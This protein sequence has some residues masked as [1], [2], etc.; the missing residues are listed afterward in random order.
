VLL[1]RYPKRPLARL[2][3]CAI[4]LLAVVFTGSNAALLSL[5]LGL[6]GVGFF[7]LWRRADAVVA[8]AVSALIGVLVV[9]AT[10]YAVSSDLIQRIST[11]SNTLVERSL[12]R[13]SKSATGRGTLFG[14]EFELYR[15]GSLLGRGPANTKANL[16]PS[17]AQIVKEAHDDYLATLVERGPL[18]VVGLIILMGAVGV[19]AAAVAMRP[20][21]PRFA[22]IVTF[23]A[24]FI[25]CVITM[26]ATA[27]THEVLHYRH[28]WAILGILAGLYLFGHETRAPVPTLLSGRP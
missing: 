4:I 28:V 11:S 2:Y 17:F 9:G 16:D 21:V 10:Y 23:P 26:A 12:A 27:T 22:E 24:M 20:L 6:A 3:A 8:V 5:A 13:S 1:G 25:G 7:T 19:R 18:G 14:Q 15:T